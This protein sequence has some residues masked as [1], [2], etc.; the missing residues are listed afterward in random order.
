MATASHLAKWSLFSRAHSVIELK[1]KT[2][3]GK[4]KGK[5]VKVKTVKTKWKFMATTCHPAKSSLFSRERPFI[6]I[7]SE[8]NK[9]KV[10]TISKIEN[11]WQL[12]ATWM[13]S[14]VITVL[15]E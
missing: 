1:V 6:Q 10:K 13:L 14:P 5:K 15:K 7:K 11:W 9:V 3:K 2:K 8:N 12:P 4:L